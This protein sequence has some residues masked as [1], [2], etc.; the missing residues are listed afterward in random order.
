MTDVLIIGA[1]S[2]GLALAYR[3]KQLGITPRIIDAAPQ[4]ASSWRGRHDQL[5]LNTH[6]SISNI[7]G[8]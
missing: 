6:K 5:S 8:L 4:V 7:P 1:G 2:A 3:L